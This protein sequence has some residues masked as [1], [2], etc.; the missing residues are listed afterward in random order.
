M[1]PDNELSLT[2]EVSNTTISILHGL[3]MK[4]WSQFTSKSRKWVSDQTFSRNPISDS[5]IILHE[6][7]HFFSDYES[8]DRLIIQNPTLDSGSEWFENTR[9]DKSRSGLLTFVIG[10]EEKWDYIKVIR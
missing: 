2:F 10:G 1:I 3:Q 9:G 6:H 7:Y 5:D 4:V 8:S